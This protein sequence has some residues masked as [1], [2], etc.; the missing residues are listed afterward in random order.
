M[1]I[2]CTIVP[3]LPLLDEFAQQVDLYHAIPASSL[4]PEYTMHAHVNVMT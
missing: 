3:F 1:D 4:R 2:H